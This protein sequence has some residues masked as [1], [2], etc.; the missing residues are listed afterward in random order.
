MLAV[1]SLGNSFVRI[2]MEFV[3]ISVFAFAIPSN[4]E[5]QISLRHYFRLI[6]WLNMLNSCIDWRS[7]HNIFLILGCPNLRFRF[8]LFWIYWKLFVALNYGVI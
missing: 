4:I 3:S 5:L 6:C 8:E 2:F 7:D 1:K